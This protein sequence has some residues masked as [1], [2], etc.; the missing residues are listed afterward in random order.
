MAITSNLPVDD[1]APSTVLLHFFISGESRALLA[2]STYTRDYLQPYPRTRT[3][4]HTLSHPKPPAIDST[5]VLSRYAALLSTHVAILRLMIL[6]VSRYH[7]LPSRRLVLE[8]LEAL[9]RFDV[10]YKAAVTILVEASAK[11]VQESSRVAATDRFVL[12]TW[13]N[14]LCALWLAREEARTDAEHALWLALVECQAGLLNALLADQQARHRVQKAA[15]A[16]V[17]R[18]VREAAIIQYYADNVWLAKQKPPRYVAVALSPFFARA[19]TLDDVDQAVAPVL[20]KMLLRS[21]EIALSALQELTL[22]VSFDASTMFKSRWLA[23][24]TTQLVSTSEAVR[25]DAAAAF[26]ALVER[27]RE[28]AVV[29]TIVAEF[30]APLVAGKVTTWLHRQIYY[31]QL[32]KFAGRFASIDVMLLNNAVT[33]L[34]KE[35]NDTALEPLIAL[36][37]KMLFLQTTSNDQQQQQQQAADETSPAKAMTL[38]IKGLEHSKPAVRQAWYKAL[39]HAMPDT[40]VLDQSSLVSALP[41]LLG[42]LLKAAL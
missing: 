25:V 15:M 11:A 3:Y 21:P 14:K 20:E 7:D 27:S 38:L 32:A 19:L 12:L 17:R 2:A 34:A 36:A 4:A 6:T 22:A 18:T 30:M 26:T 31:E 40:L 9:S 35:N 1:V 29:E 23:P 39:G 8:V 24:L 5:R 37:V 28:Q 13:A 16:S 33:M 42:V 10:F 41:D